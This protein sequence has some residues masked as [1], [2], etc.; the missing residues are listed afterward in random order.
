LPGE[1]TIPDFIVENREPYFSA[2][3]SADKILST[4]GNIDVGAMEDLLKKLLAK[5]FLSV[6]EKASG[7]G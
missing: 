5:Q 4:T 3:E 2:L 6:I 1:R 7:K